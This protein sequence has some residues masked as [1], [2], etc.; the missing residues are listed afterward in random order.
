MARPTKQTAPDTVDPQFVDDQQPEFGGPDP[1]EETPDE[2]ALSAQ[3]ET[4]LAALG[5]SLDKKFRDNETKRQ[6]IELRWL[7]DLRQYHG[8]YDA[9]VESAIVE[10]KGCTLFLNITKPKTHAF[11]ARVMDMVLPTDEKNWGLE[12]TP[13]PELATS[14]QPDEQAIDPATQQPM[15]TDQGHPV[16]QKDLDSATKTEADER[17]EK[18]EDEVADQFAEADYNAVQRKAIDQM[19]KLGTSVVMGPFIKDEWRVKWEPLVDPTTK[20]THYQRKLVPNEDKRP[21]LQW[22]DVWDFYPDMTA[23]EPKGWAFSFVQQF[24]N[25]HQLRKMAKQFNW[26]EEQVDKVL[27]TTPFNIRSLTWMNELKQLSETSNVLDN[28]YRVLRYYGEID[29]DDLRLVGKDPDKLGVTD[30]TYAVVWM[31]A[32][33]ILKIDLNP[34]DS[35]EMPFSVAYCDKDEASPFGSGIPRLMRGEQE[36]ANSSWRM[37]HDNGGLSVCPQTVMKVNSV[38]PADGDPHMRPKKVWYVGDDVQDIGR[39][40]AQFSVDSHQEELTNLLQL[41]IRFADDVT[42]LPLLM[43]GDQAPHI[44]QTAQGMSLLYNASTVV[45]RRS[46]KLYDDHMIV[47]LV[48]RFYDWNMQFNPRD[49]IKGDFRAIAR[50]SS[51]LLDKEQQGAAYTDMMQLAMQPTWEPYVDKE[52]LIRKAL[53]AK[54]IEDVI[55]DADTIKANLKAQQDAAAAAAQAGGKPGADPQMLAIEQEKV[56]AMKDANAVAR[57]R[58]AADERNMDKRLQIAKLTTDGN[59]AAKI[60]DRK[61]AEDGNNQRSNAEMSLKERMGSGI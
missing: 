16:L 60:A 49:D 23:N 54:R 32:G 36:S 19:A 53:K 47:P 2:Q 9:D 61:I 52:K 55:L 12:A 5:Q 57:E 38:I 15:A 25:E 28:R 48:G 30:I 14:K 33:I 21:S 6:Y 40:F 11:S 29:R 42:Q 17:A 31:C 7:E 50:G 59:S 37:L 27:E 3:R 4:D 41:G 24:A 10:A 51:T 18:M 20:K 45:L 34:L 26:I 56:A 43:Q 44:T 35:G 39:V 46:V 22:V 13:V 8:R 58:I 1:V